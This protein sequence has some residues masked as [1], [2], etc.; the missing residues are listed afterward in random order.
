MLKNILS[1]ENA[2]KI[3]KYTLIWISIYWLNIWITFF[4]REI[5]L[6]SSENSYFITMSII[7]IYSFIMSLKIIFKVDF[8]VIILIKYL[9]YLISFSSMNYFL[10]ICLKNSFWENYIYLIIIFITTILAII[11]YFVYSSFVFHKSIKW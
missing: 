8:K 5:L 6:F 3:I 10:V 9:F 11:K 4:C 7:A 2:K 1:E